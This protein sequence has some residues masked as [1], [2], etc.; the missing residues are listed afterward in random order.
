MNHCRKRGADH[1]LKAL[2]CCAVAGAVF[3]V[4]LAII[5]GAILEVL[6]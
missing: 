3:G 6:R 2:I 5:V 4:W 1:S